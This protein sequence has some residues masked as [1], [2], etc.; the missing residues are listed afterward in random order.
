MAV[1]PIPYLTGERK[2]T[3]PAAEM[4]NI[5]TPWAEDAVK[6]AVECGILRG[7]ETGNYRLRDNCTREMMLVFL[8]RAQNR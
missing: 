8:H 6:W 4:D 7:D 2:L 1:Y 3:L 5:P